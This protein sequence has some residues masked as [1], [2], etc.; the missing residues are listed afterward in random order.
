MS[1]VR[2]VPAEVRE[3]YSGHRQRAASRL[4]AVLA[5][6]PS[7]LVV[8][9]VALPLCIAIAQACGAPAETG[10]ITGIVGGLIVGLISGSPLQVSGPAAGLVVLVYKTIGEFG[11]A[12]LGLA[13]LLAGLMQF[14][15]GLLKWGHWFRAVSPAVIHGMLAGI[16]LVIIASQIHVLVDDVP[17]GNPIE[18]FR[19]I[20]GAF[21]KAFNDHDAEYPHHRSAAIVGL[22][23]IL[24]LMLWNSFKPR[25]LRYIPGA[26][27]AVVVGGTIAW[28]IPNDIK[29]VAVQS[30]L[31]SAITP[32]HQIDRELLW[33]RGIW[34]A[35]ATIALVASAETLLCASAIDRMHTG[36]RADYN[37]ELA[38]QG[39]G[40]MICGSMGL[41]PMTGVIVRSAANVEAG[42][43]SRWSAVLHGAWLLLFVA[44]LPDLLKLVPTTS[45]AAILVV[46]GYKLV[47]PKEICQLWRI[48]RSEAIILVVTAAMIVCTDLLIGVVTGIVIALA[49]LVW[50]FSH[51]KIQTEHDRENRRSVMRLEGAATFLRLPLLADAL[52]K[53]PANTELHVDF[54][55]LTY[56]DHASLE[57][58]VNWEKQHEAAGGS[59]IIDW[60][61]FH[62][63]FRSPRARSA[64]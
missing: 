43:K 6:L 58:F 53:V 20:P 34:Q 1:A 44:F 13:V 26:L 4:T 50:T 59:L 8:F 31:L 54:E 9:M 56:V 39:V 51:L 27:V 15:A 10:I 5:D 11:L 28:Y 3:G 30:D 60:D 22:S 17:T 35:A 25:S 21:W 29:D 63:R 64:V 33:N 55:H 24:S 61:S 38:A 18:N 42:A 32:I 49:K 46:V 14:V 7:S 62:A 47:N 40:N 19:S 12:G 52:A 2:F 45:L 36:P 37:R 23:A 41:L 16:G 57:T 48:S